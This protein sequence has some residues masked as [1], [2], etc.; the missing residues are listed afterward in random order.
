V[1]FSVNYGGGIEG[2]PRVWLGGI[3]I[4]G[5]AMSRSLGDTVAHT[6]GV[7]SIPEIFERDINPELDCCIILAT[8]GLWE[9][10]TDQEAIDMVSQ[11]PEPRIAVENLINEANDR[12]I[13][14]EQV[15]DDTTVC[16]AFL[17]SWIGGNKI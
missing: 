12:W 6:A 3:D 1:F 17:G 7:S 9:F 16:V 8:D 14:E 4:P 2:P 5:L 10:I 11:S 13:K 15:V